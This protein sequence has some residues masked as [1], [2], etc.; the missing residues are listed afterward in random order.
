[1]GG[2]LRK[3]VFLQRPVLSSEEAA[4]TQTHGLD[5]PGSDGQPDKVRGK[6]L[7]DQQAQAY[8]ATSGDYRVLLAWRSSRISS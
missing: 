1:M 6:T 5:V 4:V 8:L 7:I 3:D 2:V